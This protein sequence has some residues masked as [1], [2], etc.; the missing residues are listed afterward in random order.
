MTGGSSLGLFGYVSG[1]IV[2]ISIE[3]AK[4][5]GGVGSFSGG[6]V[7][8][9]N[10]GTISDCYVSG[11]NITPTGFSFIG[12]LVGSSSSAISDY[13]VNNNAGSVSSGTAIGSLIDSQAGMVTACYAGG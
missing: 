2:H 3:N 10:S 13:Y 4:M 9:Q 11:G 6:L 1:T 7:R 5:T 8:H 12:S